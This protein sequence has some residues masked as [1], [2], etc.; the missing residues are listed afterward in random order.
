MQWKIFLPL[1]L[2][3]FLA[4]LGLRSRAQGARP[5]AEES[6]MLIELGNEVCPVMGN[7]VDQKTYIEWN[8]LRVGFCCPGCDTRFLADPETALDTTEADWRAARDAVL[9]YLDASGPERARRLSKIRE[10]WKVIRE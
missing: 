2:I 9:G 5:A 8:H 6:G 7:D 3:G 1:F 10:R 4:A